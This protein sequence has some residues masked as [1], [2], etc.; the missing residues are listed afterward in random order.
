VGNVFIWNIIENRKNIT[1]VLHSEHKMCTNYG[2]YTHLSCVCPRLHSF[3]INSCNSL[4][5]NVF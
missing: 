1:L 5:Y 4:T 2:F 3:L